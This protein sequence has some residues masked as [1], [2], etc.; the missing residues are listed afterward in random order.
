MFIWLFHIKNTLPMY[1]FD[2]FCYSNPNFDWAKVIFAY[3]VYSEKLCH[4]LPGTSRWSPPWWGPSTTW[5]AWS[6]SATATPW[7]TTAWG[8]TATHWRSVPVSAP[9]SSTPAPAE[10]TTTAVSPTKTS[11]TSAVLTPWWTPWAALHAVAP[12]VVTA[13]TAPTHA[14]HANPG[15]SIPWW[16]GSSW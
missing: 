10:P 1:N 5:A 6:T 7:R 2:L 12:T 11:A 3:Q 13:S 15:T 8:W 16:R 9:K 4:N 14:P